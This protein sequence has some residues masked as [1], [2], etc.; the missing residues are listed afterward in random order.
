M[1]L[2]PG[3]RTTPRTVRTGRTMTFEPSGIEP[4]GM[5]LNITEIS[6]GSSFAVQSNVPRSWS[7]DT[8]ISCHPERSEGPASC[9]EQQVLRFAQDDNLR[10]GFSALARD[11]RLRRGF[12]AGPPATLR[13]IRAWASPNRSPIGP[14]PNAR[15]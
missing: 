2:S 1:D 3:M 13:R 8:V 10:R 7:E 15:G 14:L 9:R 5:N 11:R 6:D 12:P 4:S